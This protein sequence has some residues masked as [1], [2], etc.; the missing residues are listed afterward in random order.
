MEGLKGGRFE[1]WKVQVMK[2]C[3][4]EI[5]AVLLAFN[6]PISNRIKLLTV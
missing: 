3:R 6:L 1:G 5:L 2:F 4:L